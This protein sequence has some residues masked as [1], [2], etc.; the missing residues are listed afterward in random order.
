M[1]IVFVTI[2]A[3]PESM[4]CPLSLRSRLM[5]MHTSRAFQCTHHVVSRRNFSCRALASVGEGQ[6]R[7]IRGKIFVTKDVRQL[8]YVPGV[9]MCDLFC[10]FRMSAHDSNWAL[11]DAFCCQ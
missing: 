9:K 10:Y 1:H 4:K 7:L 5:P 6:P 11:Y 2:P 8:C 3:S